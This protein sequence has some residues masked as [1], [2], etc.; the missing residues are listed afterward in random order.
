MPFERT[1]VI[2]QDWSAHHQPVAEGAMTCT[3]EVQGPHAGAGGFNGTTGR[4]TPGARP[5]LYR[6]PA[7]VQATFR[8]ADAEQAEQANEARRYLVA[9]TADAPD[10]PYAALVRV[11]AA[12]ADALLVGR[13][14]YVEDVTFSNERFQRDLVCTLAAVSDAP[15][16]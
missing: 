6:G 5:T 10:I 9:I 8:P 2:H 4:Q 11:T 15:A 7:R 16:P 14:L 13:Y 1:R 3:V 12:P